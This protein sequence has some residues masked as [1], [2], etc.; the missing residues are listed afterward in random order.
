MELR[1]CKIEGPGSCVRPEDFVGNELHFVKDN[2]I[3]SHQPMPKDFNYP[4][5]AV[6]GG[7]QGG[8]TK[9][10]EFQFKLPD[11]MSGDKVLLQWK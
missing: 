6:Y 5:R 7:G 2:A 10:F 4:E 9:N 8:G 1:A 3:G 11:G